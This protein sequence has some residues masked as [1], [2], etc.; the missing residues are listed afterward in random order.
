MVS[1]NQEYGRREN[2]ILGFVIHMTEGSFQSAID[3]CCNPKSQVSYHVIIDRNGDD[4]T[5]VMPE[6]TAWHAGLRN[7]SAEY[8]KFL[9]LNPNLTTIGIALAGISEHGPSIDQITKCAKL[10]NTLAL[11]YDIALDKNTIIPHHDIRSDKICPGVHTSIGA[12]LYL[13]L[14]PQA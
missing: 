3:W 7:N 1:P 2:K 6:N 13:S 11:Y 14:L 9:G 4:I 8:T 10:I 5:L 12:I